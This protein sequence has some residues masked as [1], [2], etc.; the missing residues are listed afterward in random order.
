L[1]L[2]LL[3]AAI[4]L[5]GCNS[6]TSSSPN[7]KPAFTLT[8]SPIAL[9]LAQGGSGTVTLTTAVSNGF[10]AAVALSVSGQPEGVT[11]A[12]SSNSIAAPG[13]GSST[14]TI[15]VA[16]IVAA[17]NYAFSITGAGQEQAHS[18]V[19]K[20]TV[21]AHATPY[22]VGYLTPW[23][24]SF[25][26]FAKTLDFTKMT[27]LNLLPALLPV[28]S[29]A[30]TAKSDMT[31]SIDN[32][33]DAEIDALVEAAHKAGVMVLVSIT[34]DNKNISQ[35]YQAGLSAPVV[36][37]LASFVQAHNFDGVDADLE[38][39]TNMG[40]DYDTFIAT[41]VAK[42]H[43]E[44]KLVT[45]AVAEW[46]VSQNAMSLT[47]LHQFDFLNVMVY[48]NLA[49]DQAALAYFSS[50]KEPA[51]QMVLG[52]PF[53]GQNADGS[54]SETYAA[55]LAAYPKAWQTD[56]VSGG[57]L[58]GGVT[59]YYVGEAT[60]AKE[61]LLGKQY[62]GVMIWELTQDAKPPHSLLKVIQKNL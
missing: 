23:E 40:A 12:F 59:L 13:A 19:I 50:L 25:A 9:S 45:A 21:T 11:V 20:L 46:I 5:S 27:H 6:Y 15:K 56:Q 18:T 17:G 8:T 10:D 29:G 31:F 1:S 55:I 62:G 33:S 52:V 54:I 2:T 34:N 4:G 3:A 28:C 44:G 24:G 58:D 41:L 16:P 26:D 57:S 48:S 47:T 32:Q 49:D 35:F 51:K 39:P 60:M 53:F 22:L 14:A 37:S 61:T 43:P 7:S 38:D 36:E 42:L 30:C